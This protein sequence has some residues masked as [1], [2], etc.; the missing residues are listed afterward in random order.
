ME[1]RIKQLEQEKQELIE[2]LDKAIKE[3]GKFGY[4]NEFEYERLV[5][6]ANTLRMVA[7]KIQELERSNS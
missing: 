4:N 2:W 5:E 7:G 3:V 1:K 6:K